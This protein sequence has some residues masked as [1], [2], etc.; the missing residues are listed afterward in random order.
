MHTFNIAI[1][2]SETNK[3]Y[4]CVGLARHPLQ[5]KDVVYF[6]SIYAETADQASEKMRDVM[7]ELYPDHQGFYSWSG[8][9]ITATQLLYSLQKTLGANLNV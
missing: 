6:A 8:Y 3:L 9:A 5:S 4:V 1:E 2:D 7:R